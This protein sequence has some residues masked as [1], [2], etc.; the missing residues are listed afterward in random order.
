M[1]YGTTL[2]TSALVLLFPHALSAQNAGKVGLV[3]GTP[4]S[5]GLIWN[6]SER[7][8][9]RPDFSFSKAGSSSAFGG[10]VE[11]RTFGVGVSGLVYLHRWDNLRAYL[12]PRF[13]YSR[14]TI[15]VPF[16]TPPAIGGVLASVTTSRPTYTG[17]V[18]FGAQ[19][20]L[21]TRFSVFG[22]S[23]F[24]YE[25]TTS[26]SNAPFGNQ[27]FRSHAWSTRTGVGIVVYF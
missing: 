13:A 22:E 16:A 12:S 1:K 18:S 8:A 25:R 3:I 20:E 27:P 7:V 10:D 4:A 5:V 26:V 14:A 19:Y 2:I 21:N 23:G 15:K 11:S 24:G 17:V 9:V 6:A